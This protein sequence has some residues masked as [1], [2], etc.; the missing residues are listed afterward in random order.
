[1]R[2]IFSTCSL[3]MPH[4]RAHILSSFSSIRERK[5]ERLEMPL[6]QEELPEVRHLRLPHPFSILANRYWYIL[7]CTKKVSYLRQMSFFQFIYW[8]DLP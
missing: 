1:M 8:P 5:G 2:C 3:E 7:C 6:P 4:R